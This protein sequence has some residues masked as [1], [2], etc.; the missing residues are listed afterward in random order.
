MLSSRQGTRNRVTLAPFYREV[1]APAYFAQID[2][3]AAR[4]PG[5]G[6]LWQSAS[7]AT[8][9]QHLVHVSVDSLPHRESPTCAQCNVRVSSPVWLAV[10]NGFLS[11]SLIACAALW[12]AF[13]CLQ[14]CVV[15]E[16]AWRPSGTAWEKTAGC[17]LA[18][19]RQRLGPCSHISF[20]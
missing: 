9:H 8:P 7:T 18:I 5:V 11:R 13:L 1:Q 10:R 3:A 19:S 2:T 20:C 12:R 14:A 15:V 17:H 4:A 6:A 16:T